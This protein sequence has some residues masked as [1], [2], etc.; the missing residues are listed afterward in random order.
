MISSEDFRKG[1]F[2][3]IENLTEEEELFCKEHNQRCVIK[4]D[5]DNYFEPSHENSFVSHI[6]N[7]VFDFPSTHENKIV[8][9]VVPSF[10]PPSPRQ[11]QAKQ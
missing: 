5:D 6:L 2:H 10:E 11:S 7:S 9:L 8:I 1:Y 3:N 4:G